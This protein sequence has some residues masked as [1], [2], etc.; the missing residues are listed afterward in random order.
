MLSTLSNL[1]RSLSLTSTQQFLLAK[2]ESGILKGMYNMYLYVETH[3]CS[4]RC[5]GRLQKK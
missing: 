1:I 3:E 2:S 5:R 4:S